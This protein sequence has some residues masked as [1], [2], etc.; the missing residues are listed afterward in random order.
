MHVFL[1]GGSGYVGSSVL[2]AFVRG[3]HVVDALVRNTEKAAQV[4]A[5]GGRSV[6]GDLAAPASYAGLA[7]A[8]EAIVHTAIDYSPRGPQLDAILL[9]TVLP[10]MSGSGRVLIFTSGIWSHGP[11]STPADETAPVRPAEISAWRAPHDLAQ[12]EAGIRM[13]GRLHA[14]LPRAA[15]R[16]PLDAGVADV[17]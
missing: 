2:E 14:T 3:G 10:S 16:G 4:Q 8:A 7:A 15:Q 9:D 6:L 13:R 17:D 1:T 5:L 11:T 12:R